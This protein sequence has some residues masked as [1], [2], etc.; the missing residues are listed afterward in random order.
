MEEWFQFYPFCSLTFNTIPTAETSRTNGFSSSIITPGY[1]LFTLLNPNI[2]VLK[3]DARAVQPNFLE[4]ASTMLHKKRRLLTRSGTVMT[5]PWPSPPGACHCSCHFWHGACWNYKQISCLLLV[6][7]HIFFV[8]LIPLINLCH[9]LVSLMGVTGCWQEILT[10]FWGLIHCLLLWTG[11]HVLWPDAGANGAHSILCPAVAV[12]STSWLMFNWN[13]ML[14]WLILFEHTFAIDP[15]EPLT[16]DI[17]WVNFLFQKLRPHF[18]HP[19]GA[20]CMLL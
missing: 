3:C 8:T 13:L 4:R 7:F 15:D 12:D 1:L 2:M 18:C 11:S 6:E 17:C 14:I 5:L 9:V 20:F 19:F 10:A 16:R